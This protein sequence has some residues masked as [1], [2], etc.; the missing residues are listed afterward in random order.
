MRA[1]TAGITATVDSPS[2]GT[3]CTSCIFTP[4]SLP[5]TL[6]LMQPSAYRFAPHC[7]TSNHRKPCISAP[8]EKLHVYKQHIH[9]LAFTA[10]SC[11]HSALQWRH[12]HWVLY[13]EM[14]STPALS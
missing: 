6:A 1:P 10:M 9:L 12:P 8:S 13:T 5:R 7:I 11:P 2:Q 14:L 4:A 3:Q